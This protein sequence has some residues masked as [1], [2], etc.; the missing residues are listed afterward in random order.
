[1]PALL[2]IVGIASVVSALLFWRAGRVAQ[3]PLPLA[4]AWGSTLITGVAYFSGEEPSPLIFFYL[5]VFLYSAYFFTTRELIAEI[6]YVGLA[7][8]ALLIARPP[9]GGAPAWWFVSIGALSVAAVLVAGMRKRADALI[10][11][12]YDAARARPS[13]DAVQPAGPFS[14]TGDLRAGAGAQ[15]PAGAGGR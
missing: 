4:L 7:Y 12:L 10:A 9:D 5:W 15:R 3:V 1:M 14:R 6:S 2:A 13:D 8:G 11:R